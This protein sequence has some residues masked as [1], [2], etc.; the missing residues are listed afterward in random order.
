MVNAMHRRFLRAEIWRN[1]DL[2]DGLSM[3]ALTNPIYFASK[4]DTRSSN[5]EG[6]SMFQSV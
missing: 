2:A 3:A 1:L 6:Y 4:E 5:H